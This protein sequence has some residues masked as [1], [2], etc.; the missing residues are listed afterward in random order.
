M[1]A[2]QQGGIV[3]KFGILGGLHTVEFAQHP[4][5]SLA[6]AVRCES[7]ETALRL[8]FTESREYILFSQKA[9]HGYWHAFRYTYTWACAGET[10]TI[11]GTQGKF[12]SSVLKFVQV[13]D[14]VEDQELIK[15]SESIL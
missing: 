11:F 9:A 1:V 4:A 5:H 12:F 15:M 7:F 14:H 13:N 6:L 3:T 2:S 8:S 10:P